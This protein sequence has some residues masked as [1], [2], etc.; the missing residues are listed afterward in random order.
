MSALSINRDPFFLF[1]SCLM[2]IIAVGGFGLNAVVNPESIPPN[3]TYLITHGT[4]MTLW[5]LLVVV[6]S[7]LIRAGNIA[8]HKQLGKSSIVLAIGISVSG[9]F[10]TINRYARSE[11]AAIVMASMVMLVSFIFLYA[12]ALYHYKRPAIHKRLILYASLSMLVPALGR[13]TRG[14]GI[15]E[16]LSLLFL[17]L[18]ALAPLVYDKQTLQKVQRVTFIGIVTIIVGLGLIVGVGLSESWA[19]FLASIGQN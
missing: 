12:F 18:L 14:L 13:L 7:G 10:V 3:S 5:Y 4:C 17:I 8:L 15:N 19:N 16:F 1:F 2:L 11:D 6:Q 9:I